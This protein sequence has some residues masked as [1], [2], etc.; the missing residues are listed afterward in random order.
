MKREQQ[1]VDVLGMEEAGGQSGCEG[2]CKGNGVLDLQY[3]LTYWQ[4]AQCKGSCKG[5]GVPDLQCV[6]VIG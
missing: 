3:I 5:S 2:V 4:A 1:Q 6:I